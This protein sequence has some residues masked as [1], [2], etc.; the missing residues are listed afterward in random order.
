MDAF[1]W[2]LS[3]TKERRSFFESFFELVSGEAE[4]E[5]M[6]AKRELL[7]AVHK[8]TLFDCHETY[9]YHTM[10]SESSL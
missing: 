2:R 3:S 6:C 1:Q 7:G 10:S 8:V 9:E 5:A 4:A